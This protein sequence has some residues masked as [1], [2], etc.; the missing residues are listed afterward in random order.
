MNRKNVGFITSV[1]LSGI[2]LTPEA[3]LSEDK[4]SNGSRQVVYQENFNSLRT[5]LTQPFPG[6]AGQDGWFSRLA[7]Y[8][9]FGEIEMNI[10]LGRK[11]LHEFTSSS[12]DGPVQT[13]DEHRL[14]PP[15]LS[16]YPRITM[17]S[18][19]YANTSDL[20]A[21]NSYI[22]AL[23]V[24]GGPHPGFEILA[25]GISSGNGTVKEAAGVDVGLARFNGIDNNEPIALAV[26]QNLSWNTW[27]AVKLIIDQAKDRYVSLEVDGELQD[28]S[29]YPLPRSQTAPGVW[30]RGQ[31]MESLQ[32]ILVPNSGFGG[33]SNDDIYWDNIKIT[34]EEP[35]K[36]RHK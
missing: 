7:R 9:A 6:A 26:G 29:A 5:G 22:S 21:A 10:R 14:T 31:L 15:D 4:T 12:L 36:G 27:H 8:P 32:A 23:E 11:A 25:F 3:A 19:F 24:R 1:F 28:L 33:S 30:E 16:R 2:V 18:S 20:S 13:I 34:V 35:R 17:Q